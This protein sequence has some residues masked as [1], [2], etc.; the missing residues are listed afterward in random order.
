MWGI[1]RAHLSASVSLCLSVRV[2]D[3]TSRSSRGDNAVAISPDKA[4]KAAPSH[5]SASYALIA[6]LLHCRIPWSP[7]LSPCLRVPCKG[8]LC[9]AKPDMLQE[10][11]FKCLSRDE[12]FI[13][14]FRFICCFSRYQASSV[15]V[16]MPKTYTPAALVGLPPSRVRVPSLSPTI[17]IWA[18]ALAILMCTC[19]VPMQAGHASYEVLLTEKDMAEE[20]I[21]KTWT[22]KR[23][24]R[25]YI[26]LPCDCSRRIASCLI[27]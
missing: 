4:A 12:R 11:K 6:Q 15:L 20:Q 2:A 19:T 7:S 21:M 16:C 3:S 27:T 14:C 25:S 22:A 17:F 1:T 5:H 23:T 18:H 26:A 24:D 9:R 13:H 8:V 10:K